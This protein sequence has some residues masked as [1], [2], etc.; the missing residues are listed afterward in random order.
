MNFGLSLKSML[1]LNH[2]FDEGE[3]LHDNEREQ[4]V[5]VM[6]VNNNSWNRIYHR[7]DG[8]IRDQGREPEP[9]YH[10]RSENQGIYIASESQLERTV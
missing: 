10:V 1:D 2:E 9:R 3:E 4:N 8:K 5:K 6:N 7:I